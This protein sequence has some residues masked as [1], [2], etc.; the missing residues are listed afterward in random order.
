MS[1]ELNSAVFLKHPK[2][3]NYKIKL[4]LIYLLKLNFYVLISFL[5]I[6]LIIELDGIK[7]YNIFLIIILLLH[8]IIHL[9]FNHNHI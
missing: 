3:Y 9:L 1:S 4:I 6:P 8:V 2:F 7:I 5:I